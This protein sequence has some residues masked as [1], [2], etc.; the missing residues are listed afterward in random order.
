[1]GWTFNR[2]KVKRYEN[3][4][5]IVIKRTKSTKMGSLEING[6]V[7]KPTSYLNIITTVR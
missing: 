4:V 2:R 6:S 7:F 3:I 5:Y 1:M